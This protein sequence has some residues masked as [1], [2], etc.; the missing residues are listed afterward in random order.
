M[1]VGFFHVETADRPSGIPFASR[2]VRSVRAAMPGAAITQF[3][4]LDDVE[5]HRVPDVDQLI[6][7]P[8]APMALAVLEAYASAG[9]GEWLFLDTDVV[10]QHDVRDVFSDPE[11][12]I[13]VATREGTLKPKEIGSKF[14]AGMPYNK[15]VAFSRTG[16]FWSAAAA[17]LRAATAA[18]QAWM[19]DQRATNDT[20]ATGTF[21]VKVLPNHYNYPPFKRT[22]NV[23]AKAI[24]HF[25]GPRKAWM[26]A[27]A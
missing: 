8:A 5:R 15:G 9:A 26:L 16:A 6:V 7:R 19:G 1:R 25:K 22:E 18:D 23:S 11:F 14:M 13:A 2:M 12:D 10:V 20:I 24:L 27:V 17:R 3:T 4:R 21:R